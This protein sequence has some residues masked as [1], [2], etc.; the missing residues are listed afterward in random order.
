MH[1]AHKAAVGAVAVDRAVDGDM[2]AA[3]VDGDLSGCLTDDACSELLRAVDGAIDGEVVDGGTIDKAEGSSI[4]CGGVIVE[5]ECVAS[6][7]EGAIEGMLPIDAH[8][9]AYSDVVCQ[10]EVLAAVVGADCHALCQQVPL[11]GVADEVWGRFGA[12][13]LPRI[14]ID[15]GIDKHIVIGHRECVRV[16]V[17]HKLSGTD[18]EAFAFVAVRP[19]VAE[20]E[21]HSIAHTG[22]EHVVVL[23]A[24]TV[25]RDSADGVFSKGA[26]VLNRDMLP[27]D[28]ATGVLALRCAERLGVVAIGDVDHA[29]A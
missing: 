5:G 6:A 25:G 21:A 12:I 19:C 1:D 20:G 16:L 14:G 15:A 28:D 26:S 22:I 2:A 13:A 24:D 3:V 27:S 29:A 11:A 7:A 9:A 18:M 8:H 10:Q 17:A 4:V 23:D